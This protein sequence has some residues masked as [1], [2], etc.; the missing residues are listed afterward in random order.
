MVQIIDE[1]SVSQEKGCY[2]VTY[3]NDAMKLVTWFG[4]IPIFNMLD[5]VLENITA[6]T[7]RQNVQ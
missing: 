2:L 7:K 3:A 5:R 4:N 6:F 1:Y